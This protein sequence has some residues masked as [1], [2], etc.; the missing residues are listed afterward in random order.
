M[1][2]QSKARELTFEGWRADVFECLRTIEIVLLGLR[3]EGPLSPAL[4]EIRR[5]CWILG[6]MV[7]DGGAD[8]P[9]MTRSYAEARINTD[10]VAAWERQQSAALSAR[11]ESAAR[12]PRDDD[13]RRTGHSQ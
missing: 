6:V 3:Y 9:L 10:F 7:Q 13:A 8:G 5:Q 4:A 11:A 2:R 1:G 12:V